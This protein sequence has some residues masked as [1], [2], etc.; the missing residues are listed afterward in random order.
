MN[1]SSSRTRP[2]PTGPSCPEPA[3]IVSNST[4]SDVSKGKISSWDGSKRVAEGTIDRARHI[5]GSHAGSMP[6]DFPTSPS[7]QNRGCGTLSLLIGQAQLQEHLHSLRDEIALVS[8]CRAFRLADPIFRVESR[9]STFLA[10]RLSANLG[11]HA[12]RVVP[13]IAQELRNQHRP[14]SGELVAALQA[15]FEI[16]KDCDRNISG[17]HAPRFQ[18]PS[19]SRAYYIDLM[20]SSCTSAGTGTTVER[21]VR[22]RRLEAYRRR[23]D[24]PMSRYTGETSTRLRDTMW[25]AADFGFV[26]CVLSCFLAFVFYTDVIKSGGFS[27][28]LFNGPILGTVCGL[29]LT[30]AVRQAGYV[31][32]LWKEWRMSA[33]SVSLEEREHS[34]DHEAEDTL[35][36]I[37]QTYR[38]RD[39]EL[40]NQME[41]TIT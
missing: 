23:D 25:G 30:V 26:A 17:S 37:D 13:A 1:A 31:L 6:I 7:T 33:R 34:T 12:L 14:E 35:F 41:E 16:L 39:V 15:C 24:G 20:A 27:E 21:S 29:S 10:R 3:A 28:I 22:S 18:L 8:T 36:L 2:L 9:Q 38:Y 32:R 19:L 40:E 5:R 4:P 11:V